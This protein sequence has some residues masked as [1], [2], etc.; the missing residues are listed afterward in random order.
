MFTDVYIFCTL[1][2]L[3]GLAVPLAANVS[4]VCMVTGLGKLIIVE[5]EFQGDGRC[6]QS[7]LGVTPAT[8]LLTLASRRIP[9]CPPSNGLEDCTGVKR[10]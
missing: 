8:M 3:A 7:N 10:P 1:L 9:V 6:V 5:T 4:V 2:Y